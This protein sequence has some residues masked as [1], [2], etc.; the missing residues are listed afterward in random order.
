MHI[1]PLRESNASYSFRVSRNSAAYERDFAP[2]SLSQV[3]VQSY[4]LVDHWCKSIA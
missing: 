2:P 4:L 1:L 3:P